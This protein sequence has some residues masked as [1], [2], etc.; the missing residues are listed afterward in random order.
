M[1]AEE[2]GPGVGPGFTCLGFHPRP[3]TNFFTSL[4]LS[5]LIW[6]LERHSCCHV[7]RATSHSGTRSMYTEW[8]DQEDSLRNQKT[9]GS[10][11]SSAA[12]PAGCPWASAGTSLN[13]GFL[14]YNTRIVT[15]NSK[16]CEGDDRY[17]SPGPRDSPRLVLNKCSLVPT[18]QLL[19][20]GPNDS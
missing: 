13:L 11:L 20:K 15:S 14:I 17:N 10:N 8:E 12:Y 1:E 9:L 6:V 16:Y 7:P 4:G 3:R 19:P 2:T 5:F 18:P